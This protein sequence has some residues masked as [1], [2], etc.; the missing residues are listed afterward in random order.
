MSLETRA[1]TAAEGLRAATTADPEAGLP[2]L[3]HTHRRRRV[4]RVATA[5]LLVVGVA[6]GIALRPDE[7]TRVI[8]PAH[9]ENHDPG[10]APRA[11]DVV[12]A[13]EPG[14]T[15]TRT[16]KDEPAMTL[17]READLLQRDPHAEPLPTWS[18]FDQETGRF[19]WTDLPDDPDVTYSGSRTFMVSSPGTDS[20]LEQISCP[21]MCSVALTFGPGRDEITVLA[22]DLGKDP[23]NPGPESLALVYGLDGT[24]HDEIDLAEVMGTDRHVLQETNDWAPPDGS[25]ALI[26]DIEWTPDGTRLAVSTYPGF[27]EPDCPPAALPCEALIW[28]FDRDGGDPVVVHRQSA[29]SQDDGVWMAPLLTNLAWTS[30]GSRLGMVLMSDIQERAKRPPSLVALDVESG[31]APTLYEFS[32]CGNCRPPQYGFTWSP[33]GTR[34]AVTSGEGVSVLASDGTVLSESSDGG[35]GPLAWL[36]EAR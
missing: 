16:T 19:L 15:E 3:R 26:S 2:R 33:E 18:A 21:G 5:A 13:A 10:P 11:G 31:S 23:V 34:V 14:T 1:R 12:S 35:P 29:Y 22:M 30:D 17:P 20:E 4:A 24:L 6:G 8:S 9:R 32:E 28:T 7:G 27:F 36:A 25:E